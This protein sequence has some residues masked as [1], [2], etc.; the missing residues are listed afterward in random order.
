MLCQASALIFKMLQQVYKSDVKLSYKEKQKKP[1]KFGWENDYNGLFNE[2]QYEK[3]SAV[4]KDVE[5]VQW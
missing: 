5:N 3:Q 2:Q 4:T 1:N